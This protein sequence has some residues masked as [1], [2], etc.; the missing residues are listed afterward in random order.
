AGEDGWSTDSILV[1]G[2][3]DIIL[4]HCSA[5]WGTDEVLSVGHTPTDR[6]TVQWCFISEGLADSTHDKGPHSMG[7]IDSRLANGRISRHHNLYAHNNTRNPRPG[8]VHDED[9][10]RFEAQYNIVDSGMTY[11]FRNNVVYNWGGSRAGYTTGDSDRIAMNYVANYLKPGPDST[12]E[13]A[14][15]AAPRA[16]IY[17]RETLVKGRDVGWEGISKKYIRLDKPV[18]VAP[19]LTEPARVAFERVLT[20]GGASRPNRDSVDERLVTEVRQG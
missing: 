12:G 3:Q 8:S 6:V 14:F 17:Q 19:V 4:D 2:S 10:A 15:N 18:M 13:T 9:I 1:R 11:D 16:R 7:G 20:E 5:S